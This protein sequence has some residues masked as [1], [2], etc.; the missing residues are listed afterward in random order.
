[1][2]ALVRTMLLWGP[3]I[4]PALVQIAPVTRVGSESGTSQCM[5]PWLDGACFF[6]ANKESIMDQLLPGRARTKRGSPSN[7]TESSREPKSLSPALQSEDRSLGWC[8]RC[9]AGNLPIGYQAD[10]N[11]V[12]NPRRVISYEL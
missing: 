8:K 10:K 11:R 4:Y 9:L 2:N 6:P 5:I 12:I 3:A 7:D 1:M